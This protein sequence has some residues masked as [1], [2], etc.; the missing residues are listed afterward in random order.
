MI[1]KSSEKK[2]KN[3]VELIIE[4]SAEEFD[5]AMN[6]AFKKNRNQIAVPGF[7]KG[8]APRKIIERMYGASIFH[9]DALDNVLPTVLSFAVKETELN[10]VGYPQVTDVNIKEEEGGLDVIISMAEYPEVKLGEYKGLSAIK[11]AV[12][13]PDSEIDSE[14]AAVRL[15]NA[16]MEKTERPAINDDTAI[17]DFEGFVDGEPFEHGKGEDY[18]L[19]LGSNTFIPGFE[20]KMHGMTVGEERDIDLVFPE[21]YSEPLA[22]KP[23]VF[24]VKLK[25]L[26]EKILPDLDD[27]FA[28]DVSEFDLLEDYKAS[29][30]EKLLKSKQESVDQIFENT[31][32]DKLIESMEA[33]V[34][35]V[36][37]QE[38]LE[39]ALN[40]FTQQVSALGMDP[41]MYLQMTNTTPEEFRENMRVSSEKQVRTVLA[42]EK[43]AELEGIEVSEE[44]VENEYKEAAERYGTEAEKLKET[45]SEDDIRR[46][47]KLKRAAKIVTDSAIAEDAPEESEPQEAEEP[48]ADVE[49]PKKPAT[50]KTTEKKTELATDGA[51]ASDVA[52]SETGQTAVEQTKAAKPAAKR[53][54]GKKALS[55]AEGIIE[56]EASQVQTEHVEAEPLTKPAARKPRKPKTEEA[57]PQ[58]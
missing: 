40:N 26:R 31:L 39:N 7:R 51:D 32:M 2:E 16:R 30:R 8:K 4:V 20:S 18:E 22:G 6:E 9:S 52:Q 47:I 38:Q 44:D 10:L 5:T 43:I 50:R 36:M 42:L 56:S 46:E 33:D 58:E 15:R 3:L 13:V 54:T 19:V 28:K 37:I 55:Q 21:N 23:V 45:V 1:I 29:I 57:P 34:P 41:G 11:L 25:E 14:I 24:K 27:E 12:D 35:D 48:A 53:T 17:I 49:K